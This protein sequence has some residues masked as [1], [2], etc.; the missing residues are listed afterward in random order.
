MDVNIRPLQTH[1]LTRT[2]GQYKKPDGEFAMMTYYHEFLTETAGLNKQYDLYSMWQYVMA[3]GPRIDISEGFKSNSKAVAIRQEGNRFFKDHSWSNAIEKYNESICWAETGS[4]EV[5]I[6][7]ANRS[8]VCYEEKSY[9]LC[10]L[11]IML[12]RKHNYPDRL[13]A[14]LAAREQNCKQQIADGNSKGT[15][16]SPMFPVNVEVNPKI[17]FMANGLRMAEL[18][19]YGRA[20]IAER[21]FEPGDVILNEKSLLT[22]GDARYLHLNCNLCTEWKPYNLIPCPDCVWVMYCS[23]ECRQ[24]D[25]RTVHRFECVITAKLKHLNSWMVDM[26]PK[27]FFYGLTLF[28]DNVDEMKQFCDSNKR[29]GSNPMDVDY[30]SGNDPLE[31][32]KNLQRVKYTKVKDSFDKRLMFLASVFYTVY[33]QSPLVRSLITTHQHKRFMLQCFNDYMQL[34]MQ[35][36]LFCWDLITGP[37]FPIASIINHSCDPNVVTA[38]RL[39]YI[40]L[41]VLKPIAKGEQIFISYGPVWYQNKDDRKQEQTMSLFRFQCGCVACNPTRLKRWLRSQSE[42]D[43]QGKRDSNAINL[44]LNNDAV[45]LATKTNLLQQFVK[46]NAYTHPNEAFCSGLQVYTAVLYH[47]L[48]EEWDTNNRAWAMA[49]LE[50]NERK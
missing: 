37:L 5:G 36:N 50:A 43:E 21:S 41:I 17:P 13:S 35:A 31:V 42:L 32:F 39:S 7:F 11:N 24:Q 48:M 14:K 12:A 6:G 15:V 30:S 38:A 23:E 16:P 47:A 18:P 29:T 1:L 45:P 10:L 28:G 19:T 33:M 8:A 22:V 9:E 25:Q 27:L 46:R 20:M 2:F 49:E 44:L 3:N 40:K 26:G 34:A 4:E